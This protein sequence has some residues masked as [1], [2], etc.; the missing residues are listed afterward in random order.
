MHTRSIQ[1]CD[2]AVEDRQKEKLLPWASSPALQETTF[3]WPIER[4]NMF[5]N[6]SVVWLGLDWEPDY[7]FGSK[8]FLA[9][10]L[11]LKWLE[12]KKVAHLT[13]YLPWFW[14]KVFANIL[15]CPSFG[16]ANFGI[17]PMEP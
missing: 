1:A 15:V 7:Q 5:T 16:K 3:T 8:I 6:S 4:P 17:K 2:V 13:K 11:A 12:F 9:K 14:Q 10:I